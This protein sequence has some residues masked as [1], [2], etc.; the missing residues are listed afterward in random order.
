MVDHNSQAV[1]ESVAGG[2]SMAVVAVAV[3]GMLTIVAG[4]CFALGMSEHNVL[5]TVIVVSGGIG[6]LLTRPSRG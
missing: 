6:A 3:I 4:A 2:A 5:G 1:A